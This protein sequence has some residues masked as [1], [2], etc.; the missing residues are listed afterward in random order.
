MGR[1]STPWLRKQ[2]KC[3]YVSID[4]KQ[5]NLG[6][7]KAEAFKAFHR[8]M[9]SEKPSSGCLAVEL[10]DRF[11][12]WCKGNREAGTFAWYNKHLQAFAN[13]IP[14]RLQSSEI[15]PHHVTAW[16][17]KK[18]WSASYQRGAMVAVQR[19]FQWGVKQGFIDRSPLE[20][21][22][23][24]SATRR[25][26]CPS[27]ADVERMAAIAGKPFKDVILFAF[28]TG[29]R[30]QEII[31]MEAR[32]Y[33]NGRIEFP[34]AESKGKKKARVIYLNDIAKEIVERRIGE[35]R[36]FTNSRGTPW[37]A[38]AFN[39]AMRRIEKKTGKKF[40]VYDLRHAFA[41]NM[42]EAGLD[43]ITVSKLLGHSSAAMLARVYEHI[44]EKNDFLQERLNSAKKKG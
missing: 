4:G 13:S 24:P 27:E 3:W 17:A 30:P 26:N 20:H 16:I 12:V 32:H 36:I 31:N 6:K 29:A 41:T 35:G 34:V 40:A 38:F 37:T 18:K 2:T 8:L 25:D 14:L 9:A 28:N 5:V 42:L 1:K 10:L 11:L 15:R 43:H 23:K 44:G 21:L 7:D 33:R 22:E 39:C 19:A